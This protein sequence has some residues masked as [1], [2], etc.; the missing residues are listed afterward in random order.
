M[1]DMKLVR[2]VWGAVAFKFVSGWIKFVLQ[3]VKRGNLRSTRHIGL[4]CSTQGQILLVFEFRKAEALKVWTKFI[5]VF[6]CLQ[7]FYGNEELAV[8]WES[9][10]YQ[11]EVTRFTHNSLTV[12]HR[13]VTDL[14]PSHYL[15]ITWQ[16]HND[17]NRLIP[18]TWSSKRLCWKLFHK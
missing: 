7:C 17:R 15:V 1:D 10:L 12:L 4:I 13:N 16:Q 6:S 14:L 8:G 18:A 5:N 9:P 3:P 11:Q 2:F